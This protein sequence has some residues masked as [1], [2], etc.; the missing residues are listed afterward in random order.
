M[1]EQ[2][3]WEAA[4]RRRGDQAALV[5]AVVLTAAMFTSQVFHL[6]QSFDSAPF[7][8]ERTTEL[9]TIM[10]EVA[11]FFVAI[12]GWLFFIKR[13]RDTRDRLFEEE[14]RR[15]AAQEELAEAQKMEALGQIAAGVAHDFGNQ[16][17]VIN[18][19]LDLVTSAIDPGSPGA[20]HVRRARTAANQASETVQS[21]MLFGRRSAGRRV[22]VD[23]TDVVREASALAAAMLP[24]TVRIEHAT[25]DAPLWTDGDRTQLVQVLMNLILNARDAMPDGGTITIEAACIGEARATACP[26]VRVSV[27]DNGIGMSPEVAERVFEPFFTTREGHGTGLGLSVVH[28]IVTGMGGTI[29]V[30]SVPGKGSRFDVVVPTAQGRACRQIA[31]AAPPVPDDNA[32]V[33]DLGDA[34]RTSLVVEA[35]NQS[36]VPARS[37]ATQMQP[38][39]PDVLAIVVQGNGRPDAVFEREHTATMIVIDPPPGANLPD[40]TRILTSPVPV[41]TLLSEVASVVAEAAPT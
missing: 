28:G 32:V 12:G 11:I 36:G 5:F 21:L 6:V 30:D 16:M 2:A 40:G 1:V 18:G 37:A 4:R 41:S 35:I 29:T 19:S 14:S 10:A 38:G 7:A 39:S 22:A 3:A 25:P 33:V 26:K 13:I 9:F 15:I 27:V 24:S 31:P 20:A 34:Y 8:S 17:A 23:L